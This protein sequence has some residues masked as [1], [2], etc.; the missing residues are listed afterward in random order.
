VTQSSLF[1]QLGGEPVLR[2]IVNRFVDRMFGDPMIGFFFRNV[3]RQRVKDKEYELA[4]GHLGAGVQY[5][6]RPLRQAHA[7]HPIMGGQFARR[8]EL[9]RLT[10]NE[11]G[12]PP[13]VVEHWIAHTEGLRALVTR[14]ASGECNAAPDPGTASGLDAPPAPPRGAPGNGSRGVA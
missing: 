10:L 14:D 9:L 5:T 11:A 12:A 6:G 8:L 2:S 3:D 1:E 7:A 4:A 13:A